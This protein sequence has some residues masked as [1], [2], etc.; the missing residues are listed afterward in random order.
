MT[1][2]TAKPRILV[3]EDETLARAKQTEPFGYLLKPFSET[4][5]HTV[6][7]MALYKFQ[8]DTRLRVSDAALKAVSQGVMI[9]GAD[10]CIHSAND[11]FFKHYR[12]H[13]DRLA[14]N[15]GKN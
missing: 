7:E 14:A 12:L 10:H 1:S 9:S 8:A 3:V 2:C 5:L 11:A 6:L 15:R 13:P 4:E